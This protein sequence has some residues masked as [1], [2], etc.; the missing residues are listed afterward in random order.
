MS[1]GLILYLAT[2]NECRRKPLESTVCDVIALFFMLTLS[3][4]VTF[5]HTWT[6]VCGF[7]RFDT[8]HRQLENQ[9]RARRTNVWRTFI[10]YNLSNPLESI[11]HTPHTA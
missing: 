2:A 7:H 5:V 11:Q 3:L 4:A 1:F 6:P 9:R 8:E 10:V